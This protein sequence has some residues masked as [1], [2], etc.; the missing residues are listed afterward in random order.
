MALKITDSNFQELVNT[1]Q[2]T[3]IDLW[4][5]WCGPCRMMGPIVDE[6]AN[7]LEGKAQIGKLNVDENPTVPTKY[8]V[9]GIPT[10]LIF[11]EGQ[12]V[13]K[14]VGAVSKPVLEAKIKEHLN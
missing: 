11:K 7:E 9:R 6:L 1:P 3:V 4:A 13:D 10:F 14:V 5:E 8:N 12:L 2:V